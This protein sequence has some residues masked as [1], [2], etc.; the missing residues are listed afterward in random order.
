KG[1]PAPVPP[2][3]ADV[4]KSGSINIL[5][6]THIINYLYKGGPPPDCS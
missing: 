5:D 6:V 1:G 4:N 2:Q 3:S